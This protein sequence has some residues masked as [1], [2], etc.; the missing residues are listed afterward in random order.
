[1]GVGDAREETQEK[2]RLTVLS[3]TFSLRRK[4]LETHFLP[5]RMA[6]GTVPLGELALKRIP[7]LNLVGFLC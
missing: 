6:M 7:L 2:K 4:C 5:P 3:I 1:M